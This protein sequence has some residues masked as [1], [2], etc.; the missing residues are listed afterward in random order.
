MRQALV[1]LCVLGMFLVAASAAFAGS[2]ETININKCI[3]LGIKQLAQVNHSA[4]ASAKKL[5]WSQDNEVC[6]ES[7]G[8]EILE[9]HEPVIPAALLHDRIF[10]EFNGIVTLNQSP[11]NINNQG[12]AISTAFDM[13]TKGAFLH[14]KASAVKINGEVFLPVLCLTDVAGVN[15]KGSTESLFV[16]EGNEVNAEF[17]PRSNLIADCLIGV[18]GVVGINQSA[19]NINNQNNAVAM[20]VGAKGIA[21]L[22][23]ADLVLI[24]GGNK[25]KELATCKHDTLEGAIFSGCGSS[26]MVGINQATGNIC[27]QANVIASCL[28]CP[29]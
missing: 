19:G 16:G 4:E 23:E 7:G 21:C 11:G 13:G 27:N 20:A 22:A 9:T 25:V 28:L 1:L 5:D 2:E 15:A 6:E 3:Y 10:N 17:T 12:N 24:S 26:G 14:A 29:F 18:H 8:N